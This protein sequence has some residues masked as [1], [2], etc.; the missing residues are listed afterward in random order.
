MQIDLTPHEMLVAITAIKRY[1]VMEETAEV[2]A[3]KL[4]DALKFM[5]RSCPGGC[6]HAVYDDPSVKGKK[7]CGLPEC[8]K[9]DG[10][11]FPEYKGRYADE[12]VKFQNRFLKIKQLCEDHPEYSL[13]RIGDLCNLSGSRVSQIIEKYN[14]LNPLNPIIHID[15]RYKKKDGYSPRWCTSETC[16]CSGKLTQH[17]TVTVAPAGDNSRKV[18][19]VMTTCPD[20]NRT[21]CVRGKKL[22]T[23]KSKPESPDWRYED[24][25]K[26]LLTARRNEHDL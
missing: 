18:D 5:H 21:V 25:K 14:K 9:G 22:S 1:F 17:P 10:I 23:H 11:N 15:S 24:R 26:K 3:S 13:V 8:E 7:Y 16:S 12:R 19:M 2:T 6:G 20:C 4:D